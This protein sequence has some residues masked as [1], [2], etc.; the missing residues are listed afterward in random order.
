M[1]AAE[2][3]VEE[4]IFEDARQAVHVAFLVM[5][6]PA[7][8]D[9]PFRKALIR[10]MESINL[11]TT[12][13]HWLDQL[14]GEPSGR[15]NFAGLD[16]NEVRA[17]CVM[18]TQAVATK[19][20][21]PERWVLLAK[22]GQTDFEDV[23]DDEPGCSQVAASLER[24]RKQLEALTVKME[25]A[26]A[27]LDATRDNYV[28]AQLRIT[29]PRVAWSAQE[30][31]QA[32]R[33]GVR[34][35]G[36]EIARAEGQQRAAQI[37]LERLSACS[38]MEN[39]PRTNGNNQEPRRRFAFSAERIEAID[40]LAQWFAPMFPRLKPLALNCMLGRMFATHK[41][42]DITAR[43]LATS[44]GGSHMT[45]VRASWKMKNHIRQLEDNAMERLAPY[46]AKQGVAWPVQETC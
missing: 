27:E 7:R 32:A 37:A 41:K 30:Q 10:S 44:F 4:P 33:D 42:I 1:G 11:S 15:I 8:Q 16:M 45:Y 24:T 2:Q 26:R 9:A 21:E 43:E 29:P 28:D 35:V 12:Q 31:Y 5:A 14:R 17:Q 19:L 38:L 18:I 13:R 36:A 20:P 39:G 3:Q 46:L 40:G 22:Y 25:R 34:D 23:V 6:Q